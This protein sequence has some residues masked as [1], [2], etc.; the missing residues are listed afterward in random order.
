MTRRIRIVLAVA[1]AAALVLASAMP[2]VAAT[3][4]PVIALTPATAVPG[5][6][7]DITGE[8][9]VPY[10]GIDLFFDGAHR[11]VVTADADGLFDARV[12]IGVRV[13]PGRHW[14]SARGRRD[15]GVTQTPVDVRS[16]QLIGWPQPA[17][18][19]ARTGAAPADPW[20][21]ATT[22]PAL[23]VR[24]RR[25]PSNRPPIV[26]GDTL[27][28]VSGGYYEG[29]EIIATDVWTGDVRWRAPIEGESE[30]ASPASDRDAVVYG[31]GS[32]IVARAAESGALR[33]T[34]ELPSWI[35]QV[36]ASPA[37]SDG[38]VYIGAMSWRRESKASFLAFDLETGALRW[39]ST[40]PGYTG[41]WMQGVAV[42]DT[43]MY[44]TLSQRRGGVVAID[45]ATGVQRWRTVMRSGDYPGSIA[46]GDGIVFAHTEAVGDLIAIDAATGETRWRVDS[47]G[48]SGGGDS[49]VI[50]QGRVIVGSGWWESSGGELAAVDADSGTVLWRRSLD[51]SPAGASL[52]GSLLFVTTHDGDLLAIDPSSGE[53]VWRTMVT[54]DPS[55][56]PLIADGAIYVASWNGTVTALREP[57]PSKPDPAGLLPDPSVALDGEH[58]LEAVSD[59]WTMLGEEGLGNARNADVM[60]AVSYR[61]AV[62]VGTEAAPGATG[63]EVWRSVDG[64]P[65][66]QAAAFGGARSTELAVFDDD[67]YALTVGDGGIDLFRSSD[68]VDYGLVAAAPTQGTDATIVT[69]EEA[70]VVL[71]RTDDGLVASAIDGTGDVTVADVPDDQASG[72][73]PIADR[74]APWADGLGFRGMRYVGFAA[75]SGG[76]VWRT[77]DGSTFERV[78]GLDPLV[79]KGAT[80]V[81]Q[82]AADGRLYVV[83][84]SPDGLRL[85]ASD[86]GVA[87]RRVTTDVDPLPDRDIGGDL[88]ETDTGLVLATANRDQRVLEGEEPLEVARPRAFSVQVSTDGTSFTEVRGTPADAHDVRAALVAAD[89]T[90]LMAVSN[91]REGDGLWR[92][93]D[94]STWEPI[95]REDGATPFTTD[96]RV[97]VIDG[98]A[99]LFLTDQELGVSVWRYDTPVAAIGEAGAPVWTWLTI[100]VLIALAALGVGWTI[101]RRRGRPSP[102]TLGPTEPWGPAVPSHERLHV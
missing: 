23:T 27:I 17:Y 66:E 39:R 26:V 73:R 96:A 83:V 93:D 19:A 99:Y 94:G 90:L 32:A 58:D 3:S 10:E 46:A 50:S 31:S 85:L 102:P 48:G 45:K 14:I 89:G 78:E 12:T 49:L 18:D 67:L 88:A 100:G 77:E 95:F 71:A 9:F 8:G 2:L 72:L 38:R 59:G 82:I 97:A 41:G 79:T 76:E 6:R 33:W 1:A 54:S 7:V 4:R 11:D 65:F 53:T 92:S 55:G 25:A 29:Y 60:S 34:R 61:D 98:Y 16:T 35:D 69:L 86:D 57:T 101:L 28:G 63:A 13:V 52:A 62:Y 84:E 21:T 44:A 80:P 81:P 91:F 43:S 75:P 20:I 5:G 51:P 87:F 74:L 42:D 22:L 30:G 64:E 15:A 40:I 56:R 70:L 24:S 36:T 68:G 47:I 37:L